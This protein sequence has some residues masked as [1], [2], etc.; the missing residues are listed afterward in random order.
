MHPFELAKQ[1]ISI[2]SVTGT[3]REVGE[4][5]SSH[6]AS[7]NYRVERQNVVGD[8]FNVIAFAGDA[9]VLLCTH[10][11]TV[12]PPPPMIPVREDSDFLYGRG[13]CDTKGII[14]AMLEAGG[15]LRQRG[16]VDFGYL[17]VVG[18]ETDSIGAKAANTLTWNTEFV[19]VG[20][21]TQN[22]LARAQKGTLM[23]NLNVAGRAAHSGYPE[24]GVSAI[25]NLLAVLDDCE[26]ADWGDDPVLGKGTF[27]TGVFHGGEA[28][29]IVPPQASA[30]IMIRTVEGRRQVE[31]KMRRIVGNRATMEVVGASDPQITHVVEGFPT[32]VVSFG[33]DVPH[34]GNLGKRLLL[35]PGSILDAHTIGEK[36]SKR[37]LMEG[38]DLYERLVQKLLI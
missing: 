23:V 16:I 13:A 38:A 31:E 30:S 27:N 22:Q 34:L 5:L 12:P 6:L 28:A 32:T 33:S 1:L 18:E 11:D 9:R 14:A 15:R 21:P 7:L 24:L 20:E 19:I 29:N 35:G 26:S 3:E 36:I 37:E 25:R 2:P 17:F 8:R 10:I 4:F